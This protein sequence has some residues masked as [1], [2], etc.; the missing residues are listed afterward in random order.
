[1]NKTDTSKL[2]R[3]EYIRLFQH[4]FTR[5]LSVGNDG[6]YRL[7]NHIELMF[8]HECNPCVTFWCAA[9]CFRQ[10]RLSDGNESFRF[11]SNLDQTFNNNNNKKR[12]KDCILPSPGRNERKRRR[13]PLDWTVTGA[14]V[15]PSLDGRKYFLPR[16]FFTYGYEL[17]NGWLCWLRSRI[18]SSVRMCSCST[19]K[20]ERVCMIR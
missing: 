8:F 3:A 17:W 4:I 11:H 9:R 12:G 1:M 14:P 18:S 5:Q 10:I 13:S 20:H 15:C 7:A 16:N 2:D 6:G 19:K